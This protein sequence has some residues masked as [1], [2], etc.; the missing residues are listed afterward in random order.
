MNGGRKMGRSSS[1]IGQREPSAGR[2]ATWAVGSNDA[3]LIF[4]TRGLA[5]P[6]FGPGLTLIADLTIRPDCNKTAHSPPTGQ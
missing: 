4:Y 5:Q 6:N 1:P 2:Y 3:A